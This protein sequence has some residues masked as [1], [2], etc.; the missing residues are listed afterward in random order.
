MKNIDNVFIIFSPGAGGNHL[1]N[2]ISTGDT[3]VSRATVQDYN[4]HPTPKTQSRAYANAHYSKIDNMDPSIVE[5]LPETRNVLC[6]HFYSYNRLEFMKLTDKFLNKVIVVIETPVSGL[7]YKRYMYHNSK[8]RQHLYNEQRLIYT[9]HFIKKYF[10][11]RTV[12]IPAEAI[13]EHNLDGLYSIIKTKLGLDIDKSM[14]NQMHKRWHWPVNVEQST[15]PKI[16]QHPLYHDIKD[17]IL[18]IKKVII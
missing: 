13:F 2:I 8:I 11:E 10:N 16:P 17:D 1:A 15:R 7:A 4:Q 6:G 18:F 12:S 14:C 9:T 3:F 5:T